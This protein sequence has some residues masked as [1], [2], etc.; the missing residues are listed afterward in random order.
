VKRRVEREAMACNK[1]EIA[2]L[3]GEYERGVLPR[4]ERELFEAHLLE[5]H[6]CFEDLYEAA[7]VV[8]ILRKQSAVSTQVGELCEQ[9]AA[10]H[11][12]ETPREVPPVHRSRR[13]WAVVLSGTA[14]AAVVVFLAVHFLGPQ[15]GPPIHVRGPGEGSVLVFAPIG[16]VAGVRELQWEPVPGAGSYEVGIY[17][18]TGELLFKE[19]V[20]APPAVLPGEVRETLRSGET[21]FWQVEAHSGGGSRWKSGPTRFSIRP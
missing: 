5:C 9:E 20:K 12:G 13:T 4:E 21:Y 7:P 11:A 8:G 18:E 2:K 17:R 19:T 14:A 10:K 15:M 3:I 6:E 16:E 1:P